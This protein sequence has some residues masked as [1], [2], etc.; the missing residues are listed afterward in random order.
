MNDRWQYEQSTG[1]LTDPSGNLSGT[2]YAGGNLGKKPEG[3]NNPALQFEHNV[4]PL[5]QGLYTVGEPVEH[6]KLGPFALPLTPDPA[7]DMRGRGDF[8]IHGDA[9]A[10]PGNASEGCIVMHLD[11]RQA[12]ADSS[13]RVLEVV[14]G[15]V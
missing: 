2:G 13:V 12:I 11:V 4:G 8:Y 9:L 1:R 10:D 15:G 5:P 3:K 7:N 6:S 14:A